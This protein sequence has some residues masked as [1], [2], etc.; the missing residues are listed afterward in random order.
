MLFTEDDYEQ[1]AAM[2]PKPPPSRQCACT[3]RTDCNLRCEYC[4]A[5][6]QATT[7]CGRNAHE[8]L[9]RVKS[10][11]TS[12]YESTA[13][14]RE[15][16]EVDFFGGEPFMNWDSCK[17]SWLKYGT[18]HREAEYGKKFR[19]TI[20]TNGML[21]DDEKMDLYQ[22]GNVQLSL[23]SHRRQ[24]GSQRPCPPKRVERHR[25]AMTG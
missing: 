14:N 4:F 9:K 7:A 1:Y 25:A 10:H 22:Q 24:K 6:V 16:L 18:L 20:T 17:R 5:Q 8:A 12:C 11:W 23:L 19:F 15:N 21:L 13:R 3:C 2:A